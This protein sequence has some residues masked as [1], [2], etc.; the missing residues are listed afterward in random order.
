MMSDV[1]KFAPVWRAAALTGF[2]VAGLALGMPVASAGQC[3]A[4]KLVASGKG[5]P[6]SAE[7]AKGVTDTV[8]ASTNLANEPIA[9]KDRLFRFRRLVVQP[10]GVVLLAQPRRS[11]GPYLHYPR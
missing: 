3:P 8:I 9:V 2:A 1:S 6:Q 11:S 10:G 7:L 5:Q 4:D